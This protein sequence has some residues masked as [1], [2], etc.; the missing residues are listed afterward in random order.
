MVLEKIKITDLKEYENNAKEHPEEQIQQII[1][2]IKEFGFNDPIAIDER[3]VIIEGHGQLYALQRLGIKVVDCIRLSHLSEEQKRAYIL[4][5]N[6]LTMNTGFDIEKLNLELE[7]IMNLDMSLFGFIQEEPEGEVIE[8]NFEV[9]EPEEPVSQYGEIYQLGKHRL[10]CGD[11]TKAE[12]VAVLMNGELADLV[13]TDPPYNVDYG[14]KAEACNK[15]GYQF[16]DRHIMNDYMPE[17]QFIEFLDHAFR[18]MSNSMKE[19]A[20]FYIWHASITIYEFETAL[21]LNNLKSRQQLVWNKNSIVLGRQDYQW[22][23]EPCLYGWKEGAAHYFI[24]DRT[25]TSVIE[26]QILKFRSLKKEEMVKLLEDIYSDKISTTIINEDKPNKSVEHPTMKPLQLLARHVKNSSKQEELVLDIFGGSGSTMMTC[27]QL[28]RRCFM[29]EL[30]PKY[31]DVIIE[32]WEKF[33]GE[34]AVK[35]N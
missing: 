9:E 35:L 34:K 24:D 20:A 21:R 8:D 30:D 33:T 25:N 22:K 10:M 14:S 28:N 5:H 18:N 1:A 12:D 3:N 29:M 13:V 15:Y 11:S 19:G 26:D 32:R 23:H 2:S 6:K 27:E 31:V 16:N 17:Y 7:S 4:A